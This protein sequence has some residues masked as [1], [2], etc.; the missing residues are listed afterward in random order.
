MQPT[1]HTNSFL[2]I[3]FSLISFP[4]VGIPYQALQRYKK[5][6]TFANFPAEKLHFSAFFSNKN[7]CACLHVS[8]RCDRLAGQGSP[9]ISICGVKPRQASP[10]WRQRS[11]SLIIFLLSIKIKLF[12]STNGTYF[13]LFAPKNTAKIQLFA[14]ICKKSVHFFVQTILFFTYLCTTGHFTCTST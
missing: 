2:F 4:S 11:K 1:I 3:L 14:D 8:I 13:K 5:K 10:L 9:Q 6:C 12:A 7:A